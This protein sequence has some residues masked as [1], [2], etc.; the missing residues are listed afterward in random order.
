MV[1]E[2]NRRAST[3][4]SCYCNDSFTPRIHARIGL[5]MP[6]RSVWATFERGT[7]VSHGA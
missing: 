6:Y 5:L 3:R 1:T 4:R 7:V 2:R